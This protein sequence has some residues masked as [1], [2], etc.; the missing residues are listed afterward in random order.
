MCRRLAMTGVKSV[1]PILLVLILSSWSGTVSAFSESTDYSIN[2]DYQ[3][4][5]DN[6]NWNKLSIVSESEYKLND[7]SGIIHSPFG[8]F[9]PLKDV[10]PL[11]P[12]NLYDPSALSRTGLVIVQ[13]NSVD[14][15]DLID[16]IAVSYTHLTLPTILRV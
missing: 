4:L 13:S 12:E 6:S 14:M 9:D 2:S 15:T 1:F 8:D 10:M 3:V 5:S 16:L 7:F 11:G